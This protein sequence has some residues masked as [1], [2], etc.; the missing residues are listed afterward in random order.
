MAR[1]SS[2]DGSTFRGSAPAQ[3]GESSGRVV[4][5]VLAWATM[6]PHRAR[7]VQGARA[8]CRGGFAI[9]AGIGLLVFEI[10]TPGGLFALFFGFG[11][12]VVGG[13]VSADLGGPPW[14]QWLVFAAVSIGAMAFLRGRLRERIASPASPI[15][16]MVGEIAQPIEDLPPRAVG[17]VELRGSSWEALNIGATTL[18]AGMRCRVARVDGLRLELLPEQ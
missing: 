2:R 8:T 14:A 18:T 15:D 12:L 10:I 13:L 17:R 7:A 6:V 3:K 9:L 11:A 5:P 4:Q 1:S 16:S